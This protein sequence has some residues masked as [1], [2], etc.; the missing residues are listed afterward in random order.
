LSETSETTSPG[1]AAVPAA[2]KQ[3]FGAIH[4]SRPGRRYC[5]ISPCRDEAAYAR[6]TI[7]TVARQSEPPALWVIVDD[8]SKDETPAI[9]AAAA[10]QYPWIKVVTRRDRGERVLGSGVMEAFYAGYEHVDV[11]Q[12]DFL[13]KLDLD[14]DL[15]QR[16]FA[17]LMDRMEADP[18][19]GCCSGKPYFVRDGR[20]V[21]E[22]CGDEHAVGM[23]K[24]YRVTCFTQVGGFVRELMWDGIDTHRCRMWGWRAASWDGEHLKFVHLRPMGTSHKSWITGRIR[25]GRG[26]YFMGTGPFYMTASALYRLFHPPVVVGCLAMLYGYFRA[27]LRGQRRYDD[28]GFR[29]FLRAY[30]RDCMSRGK[31]Q[32]TA[33]LEER[34]AAVWRAPRPAKR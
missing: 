6:T 18:R 7:E 10:E 14:L 24:F 26:Q 27:M 32:A 9:L 34:Q 15:P 31:D 19:L 30:Q 29:A 28:P 20:A 3:R 12:F 13:C 4:P 5:L 22:R 8:G 2:A 17:T 33:E 16:Y 23:T 1:V 21:S 25:H 11:E